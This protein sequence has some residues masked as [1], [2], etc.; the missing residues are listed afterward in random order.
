MIRLLEMNRLD[1]K[2]ILLRSDTKTDVSK[3]VSEIID[4]V[5]K[6]GDSALYEYTLKYD[7]VSLASLRVTP[8]EI[9]RA[10]EETE[11]GFIGI[12][13]RAA[14]NIRAFH[15]RQV[16]NSFV[17]NDQPGIVM[18]QKVIPMEKVGLYVPGGTAAYPSTVLM[19][20]IPAK[21]AGVSKIVMV[22]PP[23]RDGKVN[24]AILAAASVAGVDEIYKVGG[25]QA[26]AALA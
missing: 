9:D 8:S 21:I 23:G 20:T 18:G 24:A 19:D 3:T 7:G 5:R 4:H 15:S 14:K 13:E 22:T 1:V 10:L 25:A 16:R 11:P 26:I 6:N 2:D 17:I 12:L